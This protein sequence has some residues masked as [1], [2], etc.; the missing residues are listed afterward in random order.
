MGRLNAGKRIIVAMTLSL[1]TVGCRN[2]NE[3]WARLQQAA[4]DRVNKETPFIQ[5]GDEVSAKAYYKRIGM[6]LG[7][8]LVDEQGNPAARLDQLIVY[9]GYKGMSAAD[10]ES[11]E[12][13]LLMPKT[14]DEFVALSKKVM[15]PADF[16]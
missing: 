1:I 4:V 13:T 9:M 5:P 6:K 15:N 11:L 7:L 2:T 12:S 14:A 8:M 3:K 16:N 10:L